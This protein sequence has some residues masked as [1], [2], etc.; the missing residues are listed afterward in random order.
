MIGTIVA[1]ALWAL[2]ASLLLSVVLGGLVAATI[3]LTRP[4]AAT[5]GALWSVALAAAGFAPVA[6]LAAMLVRGAFAGAADMPIPVTAP[7]A[8]SHAAA[9]VRHPARA[10]TL[11]TLPGPAVAVRIPGPPDI[12]PLAGSAIVVVWALGA[13]IGLA[14]LGRSLARVRSL[15]KRSSPLDGTLATDLPWLTTTP[16]REIYLRLTY[17]TETPI[18]VGFRRPVILIP[19]EMATADGLTSIEPLI[20]HEYA[21]LAR[22]DD[23]SNLAQR[24][25]ERLFWFNPLV[26]IIGRRIALEREVAADEAVV[27]RTHDPKVYASTLWRMAQEMR[28]PEHVVVA[29]G[30]MLTRKQ[31]SVRIERLLDETP[32]GRRYI[33]AA[34]L[35]ISVVALTGVAALAAT[36]P[37]IVLAQAAPIDEPSD[38]ASPAAKVA[39]LVLRTVIPL[40]PPPPLAAPAM[41]KS[42]TIAAPSVLP[43][44]ARKAIAAAA[45][46]AV[47]ATDMGKQI[48]AEVQHSVDEMAKQH[49]LVAKEGEAVA[50]QGE[51][52][53]KQ[54]ELVVM[55]DDDGPISRDLV[56]SCVGCDFSRRDLHGMDLSN[57]SLIGD[58]FSHANMRDVNLHGSK[59][60]GVD[61]SH[62]NLDGADLSQASLRGVDLGHASMHGTNTSGIQLIGSSLP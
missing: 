57:L 20:M 7:H 18:A 34:G 1:A 52:V 19:T 4:A 42:V 33:S 61:L 54:R 31:I 15:K 40:P 56:R 58:D 26:W 37:P 24:A 36:A 8:G 13:L 25:T 21:H 39:P 51:A 10:K 41:P 32:L 43:S 30:A 59:L 53:V 55:N 46:S 27:A 48:Q 11:L 38:V 2:V 35:I 12:A 60:T 16:G 14:G 28:M 29:P 45:A 44:E 6:I 17:E 47:D 50:K 3:V 49:E 22:Y 5:R 9:P 23:W 62:S